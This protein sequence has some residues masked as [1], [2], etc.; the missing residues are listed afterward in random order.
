M[1]FKPFEY[2]DSI[3]R[4][5]G[6]CINTGEFGDQRWTGFTFALRDDLDDYDSID[7]WREVYNQTIQYTYIEFKESG[8]SS[9]DIVRGEFVL[10]YTDYYG[11][12]FSNIMLKL[13]NVVYIDEIQDKERRNIPLTKL[14]HI[15]LYIYE[16]KYD[17]KPSHLRLLKNIIIY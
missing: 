14:E 10:W 5:A 13:E 1:K 3:V 15:A 4:D 12:E 17:I 2:I 8:Y 16:N 9:P 7:D 11:S 6:S